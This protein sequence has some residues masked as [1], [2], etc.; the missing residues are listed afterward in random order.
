MEGYPKQIRLWFCRSRLSGLIVL[1]GVLILAAGC[2]SGS[3]PLAGLERSEEPVSV[4]RTGQ[5]Q[6]GAA[7][8]VARS[9][10]V[11]LVDEQPVSLATLSPALLEIAGAAALEEVILDRRLRAA[12]ERR[13]IEVTEEDARREAMLMVSAMIDTG[14]A[15]DD[16]DAVRLL[17]R[18]RR[19]R[20]LGEA[21]FEALLMRNAML[22]RLVEDEVRITPASI[23]QA[24]RLRFGTRYRCRII[25]ADSARTISEAHDRI[26]DGESFARVAAEMS[27]DVS[28]MRGGL[29]DPVSPADTSYPSAIRS[30]IEEIEPH[31][32][33][34]PIVL[35][36]GFALV[37]VDE[38]IP[39]RDPALSPAQ[40]D[41]LLERDARRRQER[42]LMD[43]LAR[44]LFAEAD[45]VILDPSLRSSWERRNPQ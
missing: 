30:A 20:R 21:R 32:V 5:V 4:A 43:D 31:T 14:V 2:R 39:A 41:E 24:Y 22:R 38:V 16:D 11:A 23:D 13:G 40:L 34:D 35:E 42:I 18:I 29:I 37:R 7:D 36:S 44:R 19:Q 28:A 27:T 1:T 8:A 17:E 33:S 12:C 45:V 9:E 15:S 6:R 3:D 25:T 10:A 26:L